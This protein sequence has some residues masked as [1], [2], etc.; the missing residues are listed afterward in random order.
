[1]NRQVTPAYDTDHGKAH[2]EG[3]G[4]KGMMRSLKSWKLIGAFACLVIFASNIWTMSRWSEARGVYDDICYLRQAHLFQRFGLAGIDTNFVS[5]DDNYVSTKLKEINF[6]TWREPLSAPCH[7]AIPAT[8][9]LVLQYPPGTGFLLAFFPAGFQVVPLY[10]SATLVVLICACAA[11][12]RAQTGARVIA[13]SAFGCAATYFMINPAKASYSVAPTMAACALAGILTAQLFKAKTPGERFLVTLLLG[14]LLGIS[15]NFR[16]PN[17][18]LVIGYCIYFLA[19]FAVSRR[20][21]AFVQGAGFGAAF[22][23]GI[24]PTLW[25]NAVNAGSPLST[26][27]GPGDAVP[28]DWSFSIVPQYFRDLQGPLLFCTV[29]WT[30]A[31]IF[32]KRGQGSRKVALIVAGN[33][34]VGL[35]YFMTHPIFTPY[36]TI[37]L[38]MLSLWSLL[39]GT[40]TLDRS[41]QDTSMQAASMQDIPVPS[42][43]LS[44]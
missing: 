7:T 19:A 35:T 29:V 24:G 38:A 26:T 20:L 13:A 2:W 11:I 40:L 21:D 12:W 5:D 33:L 3:L 18:F 32:A 6:P 31:V 44:R 14:L 36:Y 23:V 43:P 41:V 42:L 30:A 28:M 34:V 9:K 17:L 1:M 27:Y 16:L 10:I 8:H 4:E 25:A 37:P 22:L 15:V 39:F